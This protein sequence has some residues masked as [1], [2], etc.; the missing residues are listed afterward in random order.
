MI[1]RTT[2][3]KYLSCFYL[4]YPFIIDKQKLPRLNS[5][6][7]CDADMDVAQHYLMLSDGTK[8]TKP[9]PKSMVTYYN[10]DLKEQL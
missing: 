10:L 6:W 2:Y 8:A 4:P 3:S 5:L 1:F 7:P 9:I